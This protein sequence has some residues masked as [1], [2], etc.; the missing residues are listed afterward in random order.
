[1]LTIAPF[2]GLT[3]NY[4]E[5]KDLSKL[6]A[7]PYDVISP[8]EQE[9]Y[10]QA[11]PHNVIRLILGEKRTG[12][13][14]WDN[15]YTRAA[16]TFQRWQSNRHLI[17]SPRPCLYLTAM[18]YD[19]GNGMPVRTR[20]GIISLVRIEDEGSGVILPHER[21][22][23]AHKEDR[24][25]LYRACGAQFSQIFGLYDD[26]E[27]GVLNACRASADL[28][29]QMDFQLADG[30]RHTLW[31]L[32]DPLL[33]KKVADAMRT[34]AIFIADG[35]HRYETSRNYRNILRARHGRRPADKS[36]EFV[37]MYLSNMRDEGLT[38]LPAHRMVK[39]VDGFEA[40]SFFKKAEK[41]FDIKPFDVS[42][43][44]MADQY[45]NF[46]ALL[47]E[48]GE[49][50]TAFAFFYHGSD[51]GFLLSLKEGAHGEMGEDLHDSLKQLDVVV[52]SRLVFQKC[53]G[54]TEE[55]LDD[56]GIFHYQSNTPQALSSVASGEYQMM[57]M[58]NATKIE[59]VTEV[60]E[61]GLVMPRKSTYFYPK[62][63]TGLVFNKIDPK[64]IISVP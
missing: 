17:R 40:A 47:S 24:L 64:E 3:Y 59:H 9:A 32:E 22:F 35:H 61:N 43:D 12:D 49:D 15:R 27:N 48:T 57:F 54:F 51:R 33:F 50:R 34:K 41:Y 62:V 39:R 60:A 16:D 2:K 30:T 8:E 45:E 7:P 29:P 42:S 37:M 5:R 20:W 38:I 18:T 19:P 56:D 21:T 10:Y 23:S 58:L 1:M 6:V 31:M 25:K 36:Y 46:K 26:L 44:K 14:D 55:G 11:D 63:L 53:L 13:S 4:L 28:T 52:L